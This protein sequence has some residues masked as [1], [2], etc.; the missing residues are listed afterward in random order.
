MSNINNTVRTRMAPSPTG[1]LHIGS[2]GIALKNYAFAKRHGGQFILR[3][4]DTDKVREVVGGVG[5]ILASFKAYGLSWDEGP[6]VGGPQAP[7][8]Q[9]ER[10]NIYQKYAQQLIDTDQAYYC[11]CSKER[12]E[13][14]KLAAQL[15]KQPPKYDGH[16]RKIDHQVVLDRVQAGEPHVIR[17]KV[18]RDQQVKFTDLIR[19]EIVFETNT[20]DDQVLIKSDGYP[21][22]HLAVVVDD[23][24]MN[25]THIMRGE[26]WISSTPKHILLYQ[27]FGWDLPIFAH[28]PIYLNPDGKGKMSKR[29][30]TVSAQSFLD[31]GF[32]PEAL[33]NFLMILGW[34]PTDQREILTLDEYVAEF[35]P[36]DVSKKS[37]VFDLVKLRWMNGLYLRKM[38]LD[39][40]LTA[41]EKFLPSSVTKD[42]IRP[43]LPLIQERIE[44][45]AD[46]YPSLEYFFVPPILTT[47]ELCQKVSK[48]DVIKFLQLALID[49]ETMTDWQTDAIH[50]H[51]QQ[52]IADQQLHPRSFFMT[53]RRVITGHDVS[54]PL[55]ESISLLGKDETLRRLSD[56]QKLMMAEST[57]IA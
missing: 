35:D 27:A 10:L 37:V 40:L 46:I 28:I 38:S 13:E 6:D 56:A 34:T 18:P 8:L 17:L 36:Q 24:L 23:H 25:I 41:T 45:L 12:L 11:F 29:T 7:Y 22:Y 20:V 48:A 50:E 39:E 30:G 32:L 14:V 16:C 2:L 49:L 15:A 26:E 19:G 21:T 31:Q 4:E 52:L 57:K 43:L 54:P 51:L 5:R 42:Q 1:D 47:E 55:F 9:S 44:T 3:I 53:L 33:L